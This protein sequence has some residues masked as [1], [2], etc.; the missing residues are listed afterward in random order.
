M[1]KLDEKEAATDAFA[2]GL[3]LSNF[4]A[5]DVPTNNQQGLK[6]TGRPESPDKK[7]APLKPNEFRK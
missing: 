4:G 6:S 1:L 5:P 3:T 7:S 2:K